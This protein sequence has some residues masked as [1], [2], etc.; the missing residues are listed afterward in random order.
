MAK[1]S[2]AKVMKDEGVKI[3]LDKERTLK[4]DMNTLCELEDKGMGFEDIV[5]GLNERNFNK[6]RTI[7]YAMF[8]HEE[9]E[10]FTE[11]HV[12]AL[13][14]VKNIEKVI[15]AL[16]ESLSTAMPEG[17]DEEEGNETGK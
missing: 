16:G 9:D 3:T 17:D 14:G 4:F 1:A 5:K 12:G 15:T 2:T 11:K 7:L 13:V 10:D 8:A 6:I